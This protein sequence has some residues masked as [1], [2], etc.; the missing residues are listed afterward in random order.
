VRL[1]H[2]VNALRHFRTTTFLKA[3]DHY[4]QEFDGLVDETAKLVRP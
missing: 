4:L 2:A 1:R 3:R